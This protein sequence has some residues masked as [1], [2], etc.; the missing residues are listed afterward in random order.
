ML[1]TYKEVDLSCLVLITSSMRELCLN[2]V[3]WFKLSSLQ[4]NYC[5]S[6]L[7]SSD[8]CKTFDS[9]K[10]MLLSHYLH[11]MCLWHQFKWTFIWSGCC[12]A[13]LAMFSLCYCFHVWSMSN[14]QSSKVLYH[15]FLHRCQYLHDS[16]HP[17]G[18]TK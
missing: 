6:V 5:C 4:H 13:W 2:G 8:V 15:T 17:E 14:A 16:Y 12:G 11:Y 10:I 1:L 7:N 18:F 9:R 3:F